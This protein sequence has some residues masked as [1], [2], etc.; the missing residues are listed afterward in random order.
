MLYVFL[1]LFFTNFV[2]YEKILIVIPNVAKSGGTE[3]AGINMANIFVNY[4]FKY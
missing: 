1:N 2:V 3:R 4:R